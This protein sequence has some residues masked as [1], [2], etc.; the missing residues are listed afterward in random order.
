MARKPTAKPFRLKYTNGKKA[1]RTAFFQIANE[2]MP[3]PAVDQ[4]INKKMEEKITQKVDQAMSKPGDSPALVKAWSPP[5]SG[6]VLNP[7]PKKKEKT[8]A[9]NKKIGKILGKIAK[10]ASVALTHGLDAVYG[11]GK[12]EAKEGFFSKKDKDKEGD[13]EE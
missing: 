4:A 12:I 8:P 13:S 1:D 9:K 6:G 10:G 2:S 11:T 3:N 5:E 7:E